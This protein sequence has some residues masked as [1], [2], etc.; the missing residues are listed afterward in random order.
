VL[1]QPPLQTEPASENVPMLSPEADAIIQSNRPLVSCVANANSKAT[2]HYNPKEIIESIRADKL[3]TLR[4]PILK[5]RETFASVM[6]SSSGDRK[7]A[8][9]AVDESKKRLPCV[10]WSGTFR[11][12][13]KPVPEKLL[14]YSGLFCADLDGL[15]ERLPETRQKLMR[16]PCAVA[17]FTSPTGDG[18]KCVVR[19][20]VDADK[21]YRSYLAVKKHVWDLCGVEIDESCKDVGRLCFLSHDPEAYLNENAVEL[22]PVEETAHF[23]ESKSSLTE[24][25]LTARRKI[26]EEMLGEIEW[27]SDV[28]GFRDCPNMTAHSTADKPQDFRIM[29]DDKPVPTLKCFH[30]SCHRI[31]EAL[32][33]TFRSRI[34][35]ASN[36]KPEPLVRCLVDLAAA[37]T[38]DPNTL[39]G[40]RFLCRGGGLLFVG[41]SG[42][43]KSTAVIQMGICWTVGRE[44]FGMKPAK[45][46]KILYV[47]AEND[48]GDLC[49]MRDG[50]LGHFDTEFTTEETKRLQENFVCVFESC[51]TGVELINALEPLMKTHSPD[52]LILDP[53]LSYI[54]GDAN[55]QELVGGFL[56]NHLNPLLQKYACGALIVHHTAKPKAERDG[57]N[58]VANEYAYAGTGSAEFANWARVVLVLTAKD[59]D[60]LR[61]LRIGKRFRLDWKDANGKRTVAKLLRQN[62][63]GGSLF[64]RELSANETVLASNTVSP[65]IKVLRAGILPETGESIDKQIL[66][67]RITGNKICGRDRARDEVIPSLIDDGYLEEKAVPRSGRRPAIHLVRTSKQPNV[68]SFVMPPSQPVSTDRVVT[69]NIAG[70]N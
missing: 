50:V 66:I 42:I 2:Q 19:V 70:Q 9:E 56:R 13:E 21:H 23:K 24:E 49:E 18:L 22:A 5:I 52:L 48:E 47:Q 57:R 28:E 16:S 63:D 54:G 40:T 58:K 69:G 65:T 51:R 3:F 60:G 46:L 32:N 34:A 26:A 10:M 12:R 53:A 61:E 45:P 33:D 43:G 59:D 38:D 31:I 68:I 41:S 55:Q 7:A 67:A 25:Q 30:N 4:Q 37:T 8:K 36:P 1:E 29:L 39:L 15:G 14:E 44:C 11:N 62:C 20:P 17:V 35:R 64:Y 6:A 27:E